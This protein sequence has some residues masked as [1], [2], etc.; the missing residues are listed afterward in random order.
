M[1]IMPDFFD[2]NRVKI[3]RSPY[4]LVEGPLQKYEG[5]IH[6]QARKI[7]AVRMNAGAAVSHDFK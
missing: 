6:V 7:E 4:V 3:V 2:A 1:I 5:M